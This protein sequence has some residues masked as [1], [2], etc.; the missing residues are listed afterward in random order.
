MYRRSMSRAKSENDFDFSSSFERY[1]KHQSRVATATTGGMPTTTKFQRQRCRCI[2][3]VQQQ[4]FTTPQEGAEA[5]RG[6]YKSGRT[7]L[8]HS[9][10]TFSH[11]YVRA[12]QCTEDQ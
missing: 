8:Q 7:S 2:Q 5:V 9:W 12:Q 10:Q 4:H 11:I 1:N 3:K 6:L